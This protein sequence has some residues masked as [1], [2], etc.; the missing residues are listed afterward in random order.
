[1]TEVWTSVSSYVVTAM[2]TPSLS[3]EVGGT[4]IGENGRMVNDWSKICGMVTHTS[5]TFHLHRYGRYYE[6]FSPH[7][8]PVISVPYTYN[9][10]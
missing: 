9:Y 3:Q 7:Q 2:T 5:N 10:L 4:L 1:M 6:L 8:P